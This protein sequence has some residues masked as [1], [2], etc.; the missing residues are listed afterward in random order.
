M[1][2]PLIFGRAV[3]DCL[4]TRNSPQTPH[5]INQLPKRVKFL[6]FAFVILPRFE[7]HVVDV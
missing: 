1:T 2:V 3:H 6:S 7:K 5:T 4:Q